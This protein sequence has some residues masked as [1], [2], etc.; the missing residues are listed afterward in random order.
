VDAAGSE[1]YPTACSVLVTL[2]VKSFAA[3]VLETHE[4]L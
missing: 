3:T 1:S 4:R 2:N